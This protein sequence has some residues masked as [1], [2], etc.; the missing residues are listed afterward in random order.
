MESDDFKMVAQFIHRPKKL[1]F[2]SKV[3]KNERAKYTQRQR[4]NREWTKEVTSSPKNCIALYRIEDLVFC[5]TALFH[6]QIVGRWFHDFY[7]LLRAHTGFFSL[8]RQIVHHI[9]FD[10][11][12]CFDVI[13]F[14]YSWRCE[15]KSYHHQCFLSALNDF[16]ASWFFVLIFFLSSFFL[17]SEV[18]ESTKKWKHILKSSLTNWKHH[19]GSPLTFSLAGPSLYFRNIFLH[20]TNILGMNSISLSPLTN[21]G[22]F[23]SSLSPSHFFCCGQ[24]QRKK[25]MK[26]PQNK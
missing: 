5:C 16:A 3:D 23:A 26:D 6:Q 11:V 21:Q 9:F 10:M 24:Q 14:I 2:T 4:Y 20:H 8:L 25:H 13:I 18:E 12:L 19:F 7:S 1:S 22:Y 17:Y 15:Q